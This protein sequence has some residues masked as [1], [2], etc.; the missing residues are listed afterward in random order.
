[1]SCNCNNCSSYFTNFTTAA[2]Q[3]RQGKY[4][5]VQGDYLK[6]NVICVPM[7]GEL[8]VEVHRYEDQLI[9][10]VCGTATVKLGNTRNHADCIKRLNAGDSV[11]IK[12]GTWHNV[13]NTGNGQLKLVSVYGYGNANNGCGCDT[14]NDCGYNTNNGCGRNASNDRGCNANNDCGRNVNNDC[15]CGCAQT[16]AT[17]C[18]QAVNVDCESAFHVGNRDWNDVQTQDND[19]G[20]GINSGC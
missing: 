9:T 4:T 12:A 5:V 18:S 11:L 19:C 8:G 3:S 17:V 7:C 20:C 2:R 6:V 15:D 16:T 10:V 13:C 1:M 14:N